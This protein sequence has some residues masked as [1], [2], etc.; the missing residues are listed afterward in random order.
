MADEPYDPAAARRAAKI[1]E[2]AARKQKAVEDAAARV[3]AEER[4]ALDARR[5]ALEA[6]AERQR[7][8]EEK[9]AAAEAER[10]RVREEERM[11]ADA[12]DQRKE[13]FRARLHHIPTHCDVQSWPARQP[14]AQPAA[15]AG[16]AISRGLVG[17]RARAEHAI[18]ASRHPEKRAPFHA[19]LRE[20]LG[21]R[22]QPDAFVAWLH[23]AVG[24][25][26]ARAVLPEVAALLPGGRARREAL[27]M[28]H[29]A[30]ELRHT[31]RQVQRKPES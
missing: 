12:V 30:A 22:L 10:A 21:G 14:P 8:L 6:E 13:V 18:A 24:L 28:E 27:L 29:G 20:L 25:S 7:V 1:R 16:M 3:A 15:P 9:R 2:E 5:S 23:G 26:C 11:K 4:S 19:Q 17:A 31:L